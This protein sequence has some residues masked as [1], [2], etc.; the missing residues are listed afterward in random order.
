MTQ[1]HIDDAVIAI[2]INQT[3][4]ATLRPAHLYECT[5][6]IWRLSPKHADQADYVFAVYEGQIIEVYVSDGWMP[7]GTTPYQYRTFSP[8][9]LEG[10]YEFV[11]S[12]APDAIRQKYVG[13]TMPVAGA[14]NPIR[15]FNC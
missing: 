9:D 5:R 15:Y 6:G 11:G 13:K 12:V 8:Q 1:A 2:T 4:Q 10:R 14:Q 3:Y 7:A